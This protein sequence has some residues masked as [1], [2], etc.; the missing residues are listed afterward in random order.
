MAE[1]NDRVLLMISWTLQVLG[2]FVGTLL[3]LIT[4]PLAGA[5]P[6][7]CLETGGRIKVEAGDFDGK[8][9]SCPEKQDQH[10]KDQGPES[11]P[12]DCCID[13]ELGGTYS[14]I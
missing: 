1:D 13:V 14:I 8:C 7:L 2:R 9:N 5:G 6:V 12:D 4:T 3:V 10:S 11:Q